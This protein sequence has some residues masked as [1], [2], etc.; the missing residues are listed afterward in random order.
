MQVEY[1]TPL[2]SSKESY[3]FAFK[4]HP[5]RKSE[6]KVMTSQSL[7]N[8]KWDSFGTPPWES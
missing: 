1:N 6:Q 4:P 7:G 8:P 3:K 5:N 2:E